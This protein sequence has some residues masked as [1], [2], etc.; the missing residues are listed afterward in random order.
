MQQTPLAQQQKRK[1][2][3]KLLLRFVQDIGLLVLSAL[4]FALSFP[5]FLSIWGYFPVAFFSLIPIFIVI[6]RSGW[7]AIFFYGAF[8][9]FLAY[10]LFNYWLAK[11]HPLAIIIVPTIYLLYGIVLF[12]ILKLAD[13]L[14]PKRG[15]LVQC[16]VWL[17]YEYLRTQGF[18]GYSYGILGYSQYLFLPFSRISSLTG[19]WG[20]SLMVVFPSVFL[21]NALKRGFKQFKDFVVTNIPSIAVYGV[22]FIGV[23]VFG[24]A[25]V[26]DLSGSRNWKVSLIQQNVDPWRGGIKT[27]EK[28][29]EI[30]TRQSLAATKDNPDIIVWSE[31]SFVPAIDWHTRYRTDRE[32]FELVQKLK[33]FLKNQEIPYVIGNDDGQLALVNGEMDRIDYNATLLFEKGE[34]KNTYRKLHLVPFTEYFPF[35]RILPGIYQWLRNAD[36]HF[37]EKGEEYTVFESN[38]V[39]FSTPICFEDT[40]GYLSREFIRH[41]AQVIVNMTNDS[42]SNSVTAEM[43]H[44]SMSVFRALENKRSVVRSTNGGITCTIDPN[45]RITNMLEPFIEGFLTGEV[46]VYMQSTTLY[47]AWGDWFAIAAVFASLGLLALGVILAIIRKTGLRRK[48]FGID[49]SG[50]V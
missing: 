42:W 15:Y 46:P 26:S 21:G 23:L 2:L 34:L 24:F 37:W 20:V 4:L 43:Q 30:L 33:D 29:L 28:A 49:K 8:Y 6:H 18:L 48:P 1:S 19:V 39:K 35:E 11:F 50:E 31:T 32:S 47:T 44:M 9:N 13:T 36:T 16:L 40:F 3:G 12:P 41:G 5:S 38:G 27:Y 10:A 45:G 22:L 17:G 7:A 14:F 25:S